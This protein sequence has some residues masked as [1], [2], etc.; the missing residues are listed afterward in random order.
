MIRFAVCDDNPQTTGEIDSLIMALSPRYGRAFEISVFFSGEDFLEYL[1][2]TGEVFDIVI[3]DINIQGIGG[4]ETAVRLRENTANDRTL[5]V[6]ASERGDLSEIINLHVFCFIPKPINA[7]EFRRK[8]GR[9]IKSVLRQKALP[10]SPNLTIHINRRELQVPLNTIMYLASDARRIRLKTVSET[11]I[12]YG[13]LN[14]EEKKFPPGSFARIHQSYLIS[15]SHVAGITAK[16]VS[17][18]DGEA[19]SISGKYREKVKAAYQSY[20]QEDYLL[21]NSGVL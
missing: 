19:L 14:D 7:E 20:R 5:L 12:Y 17:M 2:D 10:E 9:A 3:M 18:K 13:V 16:E 8:L 6:F 21:H 11:Y 1:N 15:F 4:V